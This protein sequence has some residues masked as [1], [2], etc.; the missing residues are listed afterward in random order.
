MD[1][2][3][4]T[5]KETVTA[6]EEGK[7]TLAEERARQERAWWESVKYPEPPHVSER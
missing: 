1:W 2:K 3:N 5:Q 7:N 6:N 4:H